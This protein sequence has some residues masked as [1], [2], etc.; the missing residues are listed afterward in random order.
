MYNFLSNFLKV[1]QFFY[2]ELV[3]KLTLL[4]TFNYILII[5]LIHDFIKFKNL[6]RHIK[7]Y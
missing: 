6:M 1:D 5:F 3:I 7:Y 4:K 2:N